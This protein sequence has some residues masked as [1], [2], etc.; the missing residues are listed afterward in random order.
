MYFTIEEATEEID[1]V[2]AGRLPGKVDSYYYPV[3]RL[4]MLKDIRVLYDEGFLLS[5][6]DRL[7]VYP[8]SLAES[9]LAHHLSALEDTEDLTRAVARGD[10]LFYHFALDLALDHYLQALFALNRAY[11]PSRKRSMEYIE[12]FKKKPADCEEK[13]TEIVRQGGSAEGLGASFRLLAELCDWLR[14]IS[15]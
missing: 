10:V 9:V 3:G 12:R 15:V 1:T 4:A 13:L 2:L 5:V 14:Q 8:D 7:S 11:F 6:K